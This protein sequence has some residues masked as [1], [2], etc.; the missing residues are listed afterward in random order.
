M[1]YG[2]GPA[3]RNELPPGFEYIGVQAPPPA[4]KKVM[5]RYMGTK[6]DG[7]VIG[8][9]TEVQDL[10]EN[11][12]VKQLQQLVYDLLGITS[13][14]PIELRYWGN[15]L[16]THDA[17]GRELSLT[18]HAVSER[19]EVTVVVKTRVQACRVGEVFGEG[20]ITRLRVAS[21]KFDA[22]LA[23]EG[24]DE[25]TTVLDVKKH[26]QNALLRNSIYLVKVPAANGV[27]GVTPFTLVTMNADGTPMMLNAKTGEHFVNDSGG[28]G[29]GKAAKGAGKVLR[30]VCDG[31]VGSVS[32]A[33]L[34][35]V[36]L[37]PAE[38]EIFF[39]GR[40]IADE[41]LLSAA[42]LVNNEKVYLSFRAP[43]DPPEWQGPPPGKAKGGGGEKKK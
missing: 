26:I 21:H 7:R 9:T 3:V 34:W 18:H 17:D 19:S 1:P 11:C 39:N 31:L 23:I 15:V 28:G 22:P 42:G 16:T 10:P 2:Q 36:R 5:V 8:Y 14:T 35:E 30:R 27:A 13:R 40:P 38:Q 4:P 32:D 29:G 12:T 25:H 24:L 41:T 43:Y 33:E 6:P 20:A 37:E